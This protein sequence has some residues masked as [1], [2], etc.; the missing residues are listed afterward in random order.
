ML[1]L[2]VAF[3]LCRSIGCTNRRT[4]D[5]DDIAEMEQNGTFEGVILHEMGHVIGTG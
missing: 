2:M 5:V 1:N 3:N 4:F